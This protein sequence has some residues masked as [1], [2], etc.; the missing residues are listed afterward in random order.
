MKALITKEQDQ[1]AVED[2]TL[3]SARAGEL[4][5][6]MAATGVCHS[7]LSVIN[8]TLPLAKPMVLGHEGAGVVEEVGEGVTGFEI[9]DH[10]VLSFAPACGDCFFCH[11]KQ[12]QFCEIGVP[13]GKMLDGTARVKQGDEELN[14]MQ[15]LGCMAEYAVVPAMSAVKIDKK[16]PMDKAA[17]VGCGVMTGVGAVVNTAQVVPGSSVAVFGCGG[18]GL[19]IIQGAR[20]AARLRLS[21]L[22]YRIRS[23]RWQRSSVPLTPSTVEVPTVLW[24]V[25]NSREVT[26]PI[27]L[28]KRSGSLILWFKRSM[29]RV[30]AAR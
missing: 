17:L 2:I 23:W 7:D 21:V 6:K 18:V 9:G 11:T 12:P 25:R 14:V 5:V 19:S 16:L 10:V 29:P 13:H 3:D 4:R 28:S 15:F 26:G 24:V 30:A 1:Y 27:I 20:L 22:I 8:G